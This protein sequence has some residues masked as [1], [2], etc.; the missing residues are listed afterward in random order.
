MVKTGG[1]TVLLYNLNH[2]KGRKIRFLLVRLG[3][4]IKVVEKEEY[5]LPIGALAG[6]KDVTLSDKDAE[7]EDFQDEMIVMKGFSDRR[8]DQFLKEMRKMGIGRIDYKAVLTPTNCRW[9]SWQLYQEIRREHEA[10]QGD[11]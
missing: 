11:R 6:M 3:M 5:A 4:R 2:E 9:N 8:L 1:E 10:V 7:P